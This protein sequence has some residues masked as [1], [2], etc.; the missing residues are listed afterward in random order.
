[1]DGPQEDLPACFELPGLEAMGEVDPPQRRAA[2][3]WP[4]TQQDGIENRHQGIRS[5]GTSGLSC[6][7]WRSHRSRS[8]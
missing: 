1:M 6:L 3:G 5:G 8:S 4:N 7:P 2:P